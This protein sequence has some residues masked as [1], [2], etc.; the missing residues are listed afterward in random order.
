MLPPIITN[1][2]SVNALPS[3]N[4]QCELF[5]SGGEGEFGNHRARLPREN[6]NRSR[7]PIHDVMPESTKITQTAFASITSSMPSILN[8]LCT[9]FHLSR[10]APL[11]SFHS[12]WASIIAFRNQ[13]TESS[14]QSFR[15]PVFGS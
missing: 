10:T 2:R 5:E 15:L 11:V 3:T 14:Y 8:I 9:V 13:N 7:K 1:Q 4:E 12:R 6:P